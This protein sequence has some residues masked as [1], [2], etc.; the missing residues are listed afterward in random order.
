M[1]NFEDAVICNKEVEVSNQDPKF[2]HRTSRI[3][4]KKFVQFLAN[5]INLNPRKTIVVYIANVHPFIEAKGIR[6]KGN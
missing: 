1:P 6:A 4:L 3:A 5:A 2:F